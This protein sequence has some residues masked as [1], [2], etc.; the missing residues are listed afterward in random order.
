VTTYRKKLIE[1]AMPLEAINIEAAREKSIRQGHPSTL[2][3]WWARRP[4]AACRAVLFGQLVDDPSSVPEEFPTAEEQEAERQRLFRIIE[5][6][7]KWENSN[8][9]PILHAAR[10]EIARSVSRQSGTPFPA[11]PTADEIRTI[12]DNFAPPIHDPFSGG[13]SIPLEAQRLGLRCLGTDLNPVAVTITRALV[14]I[15]PRFANEPPVNPDDCALVGGN[16]V[17]RGSA[18]LAADIRYYGAWMRNQAMQRLG[19]LYPKVALP[20]DGGGGEATVIAWLWA[21]TITCPNP[22]C[23]ATMP[24][25][26]S[27]LLSSKT[28]GDVWVEPAIRSDRSGVEFTIRKGRAPQGARSGTK[29]GRGASFCCL[30]CNQTASKDDVR[31]NFQSGKSGT[32]LMA[33]VAQGT[34]GRTY[35]AANQEQVEIAR[36]ATSQWRPEQEMNQESRDLVSGRGYGITHWHQLFTTRQIAVLTTLTDLVAEARSRVCSD[37]GSAERGDA[38]AT[39]LALCV[40]RSANTLSTIALWSPTRDQSVNAFSRQA[41]PMTWDFPEVNPFAGAAGDFGATAASMAKVVDRLPTWPQGRAAQA[42]ATATRDGGAAVVS[43]DP[44]YYDN[45]GYADLSDFF[46]IWL[47]PSLNKIYPELF[48]TLVT[49]KS[50]ELVAIVHRFDGSRIKAERFFRDGLARAFV[51]IIEEGAPGY[52]LSIFYAYKQADPDRG[53]GSSSTGWETM[54][55]GLIAAGFSISGT[56]PMR[57]ERPTGMKVETNALASSIVL[58]CR[59]R[60]TSAGLATRRE[61]VTALRTELPDALR[62]LQHGNI[63]PVDLAQ[64]A[65]GPGM[66]VFSRYAKVVEATGEPM[67]VRNALG[68][69]N[70]ALDEVLAEQEGDFDSATRFAVAWFESHGLEDGPYGDAQVLATAK[71]TTPEGISHEGFLEAKGGKVRLLQWKELSEGW[72]PTTDRRL[73]YWESTHYLI[74]AHQLDGS[75]SEAAAAALLR[76]MRGYGET[77]RE[78]AYRLYRTCERNKWSEMAQSY[79]ALVM[80]WP[81]ITRLADVEDKAPV[82]TSFGG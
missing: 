81:E 55:E 21:R 36:S 41:I 31:S 5:E 51:R 80:A 15:P 22:A 70:Q 75:G 71:G 44:P 8:N 66:A 79:N 82:Q 59:P 72:D 77:S 48:K 37:G 10:T 32:Q 67:S 1:V 27:F 33:L 47:R 68:I 17:W 62:L 45:I 2:H 34:H 54:L 19:H 30:V 12:L 20:L 3:L 29:A 64:A 58:T 28:G 69:I 60:N 11:R 7:V 42:E 23:H 14:E 26:Q 46:Y 25:A 35:V 38:L 52:P 43:T 16:A 63:A 61:F 24:L 13:G 76:R 78:L 53:Q 50:E 18:G 39:Y 4:L 56:W 65:I 40:S 74:R 73:T 49:P 9:E 6:L 57:T